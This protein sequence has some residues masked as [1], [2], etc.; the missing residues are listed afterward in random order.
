MKLVR[1]SQE[2]RTQG[3][4][5]FKACAPEVTFSNPES[6]TIRPDV[7]GYYGENQLLIEICFTHAVDAEKL[8]KVERY[9]HPLIEIDVG[10][11]NLEGGMAALEER[12]LDAVAYKRWLFYPGE[13]AAARN[14]G[15]QVSEEIGWLDEQYDRE[16]DRARMRAKFRAEQEQAVR[17]HAEKTRLL[18]LAEVQAKKDAYRRKPVQEKEAAIRRRLA[19]QGAWPN[20]LR[21]EHP[22][23][24]AID[25]PCRLWQAAAF[26]RFVF[27]NSFGTGAFDSGEVTGWVVEWFGRT[28]A[29]ALDPSRAVL[30]FLNYLKG[31]GFLHS[32]TSRDGLRKYVIL[33]R[34]LTPPERKSNS[35]PTIPTQIPAQ[36]LPGRGDTKW[37]VPTSNEFA[38]L[39]AWPEYD[40]VYSDVTKWLS[41]SRQD[42]LTLLYVL[43]ECRRDLPSPADFALIMHDEVPLANVLPFL[44]CHGFIE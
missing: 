41:M 43:Y 6:G 40:K 32:S 44:R 12:V 7:V 2:L 23:N 26:H 24:D 39:Q 36:P 18:L 15:E 5:H 1:R 14:L 33:H 31:C 25:A 21:R 10:D 20:Y 13:A 17:L 27:N 3:T 9:G 34:E 37:S 28:S 11:L 4:M 22:D 30:A 35:N 38:W 8:A 16:K 29:T 19:M 42:E